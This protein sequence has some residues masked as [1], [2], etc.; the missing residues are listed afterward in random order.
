[1][2]TFKY[3]IP[4]ILLYS[5]LLF[6]FIIVLLTL[7]HDTNARWIVLFLLY[8]GVIADIF[9]GIIARRL[10]ISTEK[11]R[12]LDTIF[13]LLFYLAILFYINSIH[14]QEL[15]SNAQ[16]ILT[17]F[18]LEGL[19]YGISLARFQKLPSPHAI[20]S[21]CWGL[22]L[23]IEF[24]LL[25]VGVEGEHFTVALIIGLFVHVDR[26]LI[27]ILLKYW[28]HDIPSSYHALLLRQGRQI[29]RNRLFNG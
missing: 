12:T 26:L 6:G 5:R 8:S 11:L 3:Y 18:I 7:S 27:Y 23:L 15:E 28:T 4:T 17:I 16:L 25:L 19:M 10:N 20:L 1:M 21:K 2:M 24:T 14:G 13:D 9:D 22:Y 29:R